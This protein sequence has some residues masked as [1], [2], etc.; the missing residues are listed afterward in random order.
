L[1]KLLHDRCTE[2][3]KEVRERLG[4]DTIIKPV[5][6]TYAFEDDRIPTGPQWV[7]KVVCKAA[8]GSIRAD[9]TGRNFAAVL[10]TTQTPLEALQLKRKLMGPCWVSV[11]NAVQE[12]AQNQLSWCKVCSGHHSIPSAFCPATLPCIPKP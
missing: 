12:E 8:P 3:K 1:L 5:L 7:L 4:T 10:G 9:L 6:R 2:L 11:T